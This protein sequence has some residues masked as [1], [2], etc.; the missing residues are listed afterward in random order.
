MPSLHRK[1]NL[2]F[3]FL[4]I[5]RSRTPVLNLCSHTPSGPKMLGTREQ[6]NAET[7]EHRNAGAWERKTRNVRP[8]LPK[9]IS[10]RYST[11]KYEILTKNVLY[12]I[13]RYS[14]HLFEYLASLIF[15]MLISSVVSHNFM[16]FYLV[17]TVHQYDLYNVVSLNILWILIIV[18]FS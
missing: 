12:K 15:W 8:S 2:V 5:P 6:G 1:V 14:I 7:R 16:R 13:Q 10:R 4:R 3:L 18:N 17:G 11:K 9:T